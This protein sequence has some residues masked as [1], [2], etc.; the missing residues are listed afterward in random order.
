M[1]IPWSQYFLCIPAYA[2]DVAAVNPKGI[3]T[4][5]AN[6]LITFFI[7]GN[8]VFSNVPSNLLRN[9]PHCIAF[10][11]WVSDNLI[12]AGELFAKDLRRFETFR[13]VSNYSWGKLVSLSP[14]IFDDNVKTTSASFF[15]ADVNLLSCEFD[16]FTF[17]LL[18]CVIL[19]W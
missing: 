19:N 13:L 4:V 7:S 9:P 14:I 1:T 15:I 2:A 17:K 11:N 10:D 5:L 18:Y 8:P 16:S 6:G 3:K 12:S